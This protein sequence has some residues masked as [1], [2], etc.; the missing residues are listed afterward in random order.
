MTAFKAKEVAKILQKLGFII[1]R[2]TGGHLIL[3]HPTKKKTIPVPLHNRDVRR[4][5]LRAIIDQSES[6]EE[7][8]SRLR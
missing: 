4:G 6:S 3:R 5:L 8:F 1:K 7:E 2:Q